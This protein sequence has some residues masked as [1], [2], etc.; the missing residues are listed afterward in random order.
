MASPAYRWC[1]LVSMMLLQVQPIS[2]QTTLITSQIPSA[3][4][5]SYN[6]FSAIASAHPGGGSYGV[7]PGNVA[8]DPT[9]QAGENAAGASGSS[10]NTMNLS[11]GAEI[12][13][14]VAV[15]AVVLIGGT[16]AI[17]FYLA[18]KRQWEVGASIRRSAR[19]VGEIMSPRS[20]RFPRPVG[21]DVPRQPRRGTVRIDP[22]SSMLRHAQ[23]A[24]D[25]KTPIIQQPIK[26]RRD[27]EAGLSIKSPPKNLSTEAAQ[28]SFDVESPR[29]RTGSAWTKVWPGN[30]S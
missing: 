22:P 9:N 5:S 10:D 8:S 20:P 14:I 26:S 18:K 21:S 3:A 15:C 1:A 17:L 25:E 6:V 7:Q 2:A 11:M 23:H 16:T 24:D 28:S 30:K 4:A 12:A 13:I 19:R 29:L 27:V